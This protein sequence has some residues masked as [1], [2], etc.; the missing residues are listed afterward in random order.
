MVV[1]GISFLMD[2]SAVIIQNGKLTAA[3]SEERL[4]RVKLWKGIPELSIAK[5]LEMTGLTLSDVDVI[6]THGACDTEPD[7][8]AFSEKENAIR[9]SKLSDEEK[10]IQ[11]NILKNRL[12]HERE[13]LSIRTPELLKQIYNLGRPVVVVGHHEAHAASAFYASPWNDCTV[14]TCDGWGEDGSASVWSVENNHMKRIAYTPT[15]DSLGYFYGSITKALGFTPERHEGKVLG[16]AAWSKNPQSYS[17]ISEMIGYDKTKKSFIGHMENGLY[18][19]RFE[20]ESLLD[21][22]KQFSREDISGAAQKAL[23][24]VVCECIKDIEGTDLCITVAGGVFANVKL[25]QRIME[26]DNVKNIFVC[27][28]MGDGGLSLGAAWF[29]YHQ[30]T[31]TRPEPLQTMCLGPAYGE[32]EIIEE[33]NKSGLP[34]TKEENIHE[35]IAELLCEDK[36]VARFQGR[37]EFG[38][39]AL[40]SRSILCSATDP[41]VNNWLNIQLKRSEFMPFAPVTLNED[42]KD[43][44]SNLSK[45]EHPSKYMTVTFDC[46]PKMCKESPATVHIDGTARPQLLSMETYPD[47]YK[48][49]RAYKEKTGFSS[50]INTSFNIHEEPIVCTVADALRAFCAGEIPYLAIEDYLV[51]QK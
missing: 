48:I 25:N 21:Y 20:N 17:R 26:L 11:L 32:D 9:S 13:V 38:P 7:I 43:C 27:P 42:A 22:T 50:I 45:G 2:A 37:V 8:N 35:K 28:N 29:V 44:Y 49:V 14:V 34:F 40:G 33:I 24:E 18:R 5:V 3:I 19:P 1:L 39:R 10:S 15:I 6:A 30:K 36:V 23:E 31:G 46:T 41:S 4:N 12:E 47:T 16:L 51:T